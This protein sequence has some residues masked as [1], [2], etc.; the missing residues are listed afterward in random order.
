MTGHSHRMEG[1]RVV[2]DGLNL[3][4]KTGT[5]SGTPTSF[6]CYNAHLFIYQ[7]RI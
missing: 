5:I 3:D 2:P 1:G 6:C 7:W 4:A